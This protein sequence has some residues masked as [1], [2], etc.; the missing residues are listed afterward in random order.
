MYLCFY[1]DDGM[2]PTHRVNY[3]Q[4]LVVIQLVVVFCLLWLL[5]IK[6]SRT[7]LKINQLLTCVVPS[8]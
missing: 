3:T 6:M 2:T 5:L 7:W 4:L 8:A 1:C